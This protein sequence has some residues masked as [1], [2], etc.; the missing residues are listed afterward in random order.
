MLKTSTDLSERSRVSLTS[1]EGG[2]PYRRLNSCPSLIACDD[3]K[4]SHHTNTKGQ[5]HTGIHK[6]KYPGKAECLGVFNICHTCQRH[7]A[8]VCDCVFN[9]KSP[10]TLKDS[11]AP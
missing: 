4:G 5:K 9:L 10:E 3:G 8:P 2:H 6:Q 7:R 11:Y 1:L